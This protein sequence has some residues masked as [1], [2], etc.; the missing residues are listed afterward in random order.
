MWLSQWSPFSI[1]T[2]EKGGN[3][4]VTK[5]HVLHA[6]STPDLYRMDSSFNC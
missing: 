2:L 4:D 1:I 5:N 6:D 3:I